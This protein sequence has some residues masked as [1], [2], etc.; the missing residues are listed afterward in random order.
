MSGLSLLWDISQE[1]RIGQLEDKVQELEAKV[2]EMAS[3]IMMLKK[4]LEEKK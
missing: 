1:E 3:W 2:E 4:Q